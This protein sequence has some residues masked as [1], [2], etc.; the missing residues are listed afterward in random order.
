MPYDRERYEE[1]RM[2]ANDESRLTAEM[3]GQSWT[4]DEVEIVRAFWCDVPASDRD[5]REVAETL[6][7]TIEACRNMA[8]RIWAGETTVSITT[9]TTRTRDQQTVTS[10]EETTRTRPAWMDEEGLP[11]WYV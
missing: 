11:T 5:E 2:A 1:G 4:Y 9:R 8:H 10:T 7:R 3:H 6:G